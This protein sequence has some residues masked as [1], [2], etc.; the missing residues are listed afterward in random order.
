MLDDLV[1]SLNEVSSLLIPIITV[2]AL[3]ILAMLLYQIYK[4][5]KRLNSTLDIVDDI[6]DNGNKTIEKFDGPL[7]TLNNVSGTVDMVNDST[8]SAIGSFTN[9]SA[10]HS[11]KVMSSV[12]DFLN[13]KDKNVNKNDENEKEDFGVYDD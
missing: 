11:D 7:N 12:K 10:K 5:I 4:I 8:R 3:I 13:K 2:I 6:L 1:V 9:F